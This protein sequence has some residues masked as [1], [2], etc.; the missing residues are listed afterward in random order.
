MITHV[1]SF[2]QYR[3]VVKMP[4]SCT[5][6]PHQHNKRATPRREWNCRSYINLCCLHRK[7]YIIKQ[8]LITTVAQQN[9]V[10]MMT[11]FVRWKWWQT[12]FVGWKWWQTL[13]DN[14]DRHQHHKR[15]YHV[16]HIPFCCNWS[17]IVDSTWK[18]SKEEVTFK[19]ITQMWRKRENV[20]VCVWGGGG[21]G[22]GGNSKL[23]YSALRQTSLLVSS[24][25]TVSEHG[26]NSFVKSQMYF[27]W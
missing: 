19:L 17:H 24:N 8:K 23:F 12:L 2:T 25:T 13:F 15:Y 5:F 18:R 4:C 1:F 7:I 10:K 27:R 20:C 3:H 14:I 6:L 9:W 16:T 26:T 21:G 22:G 11:L